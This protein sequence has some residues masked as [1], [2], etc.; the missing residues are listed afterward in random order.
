MPLIQTHAL[1]KDKHGIIILSNFRFIFEEIKEVVIKRTFF[2]VTEKK[3]VREVIIDQPIG[4]VDEIHKGNVGFLKGSGLY[5][6]FRPST[7]LDDLKLDTSG[8]DD[9]KIIKFYNH[10]I[11]GDAQKELVQEDE[12]ADDAPELVRCPN[13]SAA[14]E[15]QLG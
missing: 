8:N 4:A 15:P 14:I 11:S 2:I 12:D 9:D 3:T 1:N 10:I 6:K 13:C 7:G 5:I